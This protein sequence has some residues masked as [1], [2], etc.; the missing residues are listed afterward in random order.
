[1][2]ERSIYRSAEGERL[3]LETYESLLARW[4]VPH[5][6]VLVPTRHGDTFAVVGGDAQKPP[7]V[8]LHPASTNSAAFRDDFAR[9]ARSFRLV[10]IDIPGEPGKSAPNR[11]D[12]LGPAHGEWL[13]D[14]LDGLELPTTML[15]GYSLGGWAALRFATY[16]PSRVD[17]LVLVAPGGI[18]PQRASLLVKMLPLLLLGR[19]GREPLKRVFLGAQRLPKELDDW[20]NLVM[21][22]FVPRT[23]KEYL[24][25]DEELRRLTMPVLLITGERDAVRD[26]PRM[27]RRLRSLVPQAR[28][29]DHR[30]MGHLLWDLAEVAPFLLG[31]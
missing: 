18:A 9:L 22:S 20:M 24:F 12:L 15:L 10:A 11:L 17:K 13:E 5:D 25:S 16:R 7:L 31:D 21:Q 3:V 2:N 6:E 4:P 1:V 28:H 19:W 26:T 8:L 29:S 14:A 23:G 30:G 27:A